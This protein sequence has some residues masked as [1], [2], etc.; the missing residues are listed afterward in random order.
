MR[1]FTYVRAETVERAIDRGPGAQLIAGGTTLVDLM[2]LEVMRPDTVVDIT[3]LPLDQ[4]EATASGVRIGALARNAAVAHHP[5]IVRGY[6]VLA[7]ALLAGASPQVRNMA[8]T[9]GNLL[10]RTRCAYFR[11]GVSRCNKRT[12]GSGCAAL[13]GYNRM[14]AVL[15]GSEH[16]IAVNPS[17]MCVALVALDALIH[18][19]G[20]ATRAIAIADLHTLPGSTPH[21]ESVLAPGEV[22][23][24]VELP[25]TPFAARSHY[26]KVRDRSEFAFALA[27]AAVAVAMEG[28]TIRQARIALGGVATKP[29]RA[30]EAEGVLAGKAPTIAAFERAAQAAL[31]GATPRTHNAFKVE[32]ARRVIV[33]ALSEV[34]G[35]KR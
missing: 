21:V 4:I 1:P 12:P 29:W 8:T 13:A 34:T 17:D 25:A 14:H 7:E 11:D 30:R 24:H 23:T 16:C 32:L 20:K 10:Q 28:G 33:R 3:G 19:R 15:G 9:A 18:V 6:P 2:R 26:V 22:V 35:V 27:S 5:A 31:A